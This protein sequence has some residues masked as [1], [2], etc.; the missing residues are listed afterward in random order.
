VNVAS[1]SQNLATGTTLRRGSRDAD[2]YATTTATTST[3]VLAALTVLISV[4]LG[5]ARDAS[6]DAILRAVREVLEA[7]AKIEIRERDRAPSDAEA[8]AADAAPAETALADVRWLDGS[9]TRARLRVHVRGAARWLERDLGFDTAD[10]PTER[11]RA[12]GFAIAS[13]LPSTR[14]AERIVAPPTMPPPAPSA[15]LANSAI[16]N[17]NANTTA[18]SAAS[19]PRAISGSIYAAAVIATGIAGSA[20]SLGATLAGEWRLS[21][22]LGLRL[23]ASLRE[24]EVAAAQVS[25]LY[26]GGGAGISLALIGPTTRRPFGLGARLDALLQYQSLAHFSADDPSPIRKSRFLPGADLFTEATWAVTEGAAI[27]GAV[28]VEAAFGTTFVF[29]RRMR[30]A[31]ISV[32]RLA[33]EVGVRAQF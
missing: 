7:D 21:P 20:G 3:L 29:T 16:A 32:V 22:R 26:G 17:A 27:V 23:V 11:G 8:T 6:T 31:E 5:D 24:G 18:L 28:G 9:K 19:A 10:A 12:L 25:A 15:P 13:M 30:V 33:G 1:A 14:V 2:S 4:A